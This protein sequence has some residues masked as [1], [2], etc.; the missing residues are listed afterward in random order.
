[1]KTW[2]DAG[3]LMV[4]LNQCTGSGPSLLPVGFW[5][6]VIY[7]DTITILNVMPL[8]ARASIIIPERIIT[9]TIIIC[10]VIT[11]VRG[12]NSSKMQYIKI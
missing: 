12:E 3:S 5:F 7:Y 10:K 9:D 4:F 2:K 6:S 8:L 11:R 1:M